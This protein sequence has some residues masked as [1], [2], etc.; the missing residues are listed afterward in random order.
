MRLVI[1]V[2]GYSHLDRGTYQKDLEKQAYLESMGLRVLRIMEAEILQDADEVA[3][4]ILL[5]IRDNI[6]E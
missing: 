5:W 6:L 1:E 2:D 4:A 3:N